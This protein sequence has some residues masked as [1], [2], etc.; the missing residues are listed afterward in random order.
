MYTLQDRLE[1][2]DLRFVLNNFC[3]VLS[4]LHLYERIHEPILRINL[5]IFKLKRFREIISLSVVVVCV[6]VFFLMI[7]LVKNTFL[8]QQP[9][10]SSFVNVGELYRIFSFRF[11]FWAL[12]D[13]QLMNFI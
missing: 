7:T 3:H 12:F 10:S 2:P 1:R 5:W 13:S 6:C 9:P 11:S 8:R 4:R